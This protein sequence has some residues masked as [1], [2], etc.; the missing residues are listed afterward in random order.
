M[1]I[2]TKLRICLAA[3]ICRTM[4]SSTARFCSGEMAGDSHTRRSSALSWTA[5]TMAFSCCRATSGSVFCSR[6]TS[7]R[8]RAYRLAMAAILFAV[9]SQLAHELTQQRLIGRLVHFDLARCQINRQRGSVGPQ[10]AAGIARD[11][12]DLGL[13]GFQYLALVVLRSPEDT[14]FFLRSLTLGRRPNFRDLGV[15]LRQAAFDIAQTARR[16]GACRLRLAYPLLNGLGT[17]AEHLG[18]RRTE[19]K[20]K[21]Q[22]DQNK[23]EKPIN[24]VT[25]ARAKAY[26]MPHPHY[27]LGV[28]ELRILFLLPSFTGSGASQFLAGRS[29][30]ILR[31]LLLG[32]GGLLLAAG[33]AGEKEEN[34]Q[35]K[36]SKSV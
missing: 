22:D 14:L 9:L 7:T 15:Q 29:V 13:N 8:A 12:A 4:A 21:E 16:F 24:Q 26:E 34:T 33:E 10:F 3:P 36:Y 30:G 1:R 25:G 27:R 19:K 18:H 35:F 6:T 28:L 17:I 20:D 11:G 2:A 32:R 23:I 31:C 5:S